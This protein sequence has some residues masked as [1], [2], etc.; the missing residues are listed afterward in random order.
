MN[1]PRRSLTVAVIISTLAVM[2]ALAADGASDPGEQIKQ[3]FI[4]VGHGIRDG[5]VKAW[6]AVKSA[7]DGNG[8]GNSADKKAPQ[9]KSSAAT[10]QNQK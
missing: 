3:G 1:C 8:S 2:P 9:K 10:D 6:G 7:F 4:G 5:A